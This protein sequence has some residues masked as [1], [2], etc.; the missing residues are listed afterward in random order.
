VKLAI[1]APFRLSGVADAIQF[2]AQRAAILFNRNKLQQTTQASSTYNMPTSS[3][4]NY[5]SKQEI[6][7]IPVPDR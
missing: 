7:A 1:E 2:F 6:Y 3:S 4:L 5:L